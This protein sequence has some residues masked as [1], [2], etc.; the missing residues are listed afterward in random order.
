MCIGGR[1]RLEDPG[2]VS[3]HRQID[4]ADLGLDRLGSRPVARVPRSAA[5]HRVTLIS[6]MLSHLDLE[7]S[8]EH[9]ADPQTTPLTQ[10]S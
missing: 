4:L 1:G 6:Q 5:L 7:A 2:S 10:N 3:K 9:A 8:L